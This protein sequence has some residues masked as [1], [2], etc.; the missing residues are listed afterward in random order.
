MTGT[1]G[2]AQSQP[3]TGGEQETM[4]HSPLMS[5]CVQRRQIVRHSQTGLL[6]VNDAIHG[7]L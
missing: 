5:F 7:R 3:G 4:D 2:R 1:K 6:S